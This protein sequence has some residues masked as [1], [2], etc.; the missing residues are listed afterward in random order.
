MKFDVDNSA[1]DILEAILKGR[2]LD[3]QVK[4]LRNLYTEALGHGWVD[5]EVRDS[6]FQSACNDFDIPYRSIDGDDE[7]DVE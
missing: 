3:E 2:P 6:I 7:E 5:E 4:I 1:D